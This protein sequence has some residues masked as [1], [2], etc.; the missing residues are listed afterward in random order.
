LQ[1]NRKMEEKT[2]YGFAII[3]NVILLYIFNNL[4]NWHVY[5]VTTALNDVLWIINLSIIATIIGNFLMLVYHPNW[6]RHVMKV[7]LN[8]FAFAA[9]YFLYIVFPFN[10]SNA[11]LNGGLAVLLIL[12]M[13]GLVIATIVELFLL[14]TGK[15]G[16]RDS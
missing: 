12:G 15:P 3:V 7:I 16:L 8:I 2:E 11:F 10:F 13:V 14:I 9:V 6:F 5:F 1:R 4:L